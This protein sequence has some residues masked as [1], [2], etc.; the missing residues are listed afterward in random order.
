MGETEIDLKD[1]ISNY[2]FYEIIFAPD[3]GNILRAS[4]GIIQ[5]TSPVQT[6]SVS[7]IDDDSGILIFRRNFI[8]NGNKMKVGKGAYYA[9]LNQQG[10]YYTG[11]NIV[12]RI[13]GYK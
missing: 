5:I 10:A 13:Y 11:C 4:S 2:S 6:I 7:T 9:G 12:A 8:P 1:D 3:Y